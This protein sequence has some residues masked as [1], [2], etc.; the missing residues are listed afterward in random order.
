MIFVSQAEGRANSRKHE[1]RSGQPEVGAPKALL[2][3][4][5][6]FPFASRYTRLPSPCIPS[7][8]LP[9]NPKDCS[10]GVPPSPNWTSPSCV[11]Q[12]IWPSALTRRSPF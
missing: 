11:K 1:V 7:S 12:R 4:H 5:F 9:L 8:P 10:I 2:N 6:G 3:A